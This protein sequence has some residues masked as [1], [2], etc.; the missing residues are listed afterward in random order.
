MT[1]PET[2]GQRLRKA[3]EQVGSTRR[4]K[5]DAGQLVVDIVGGPHPYVWI[6]DGSRYLDSLDWKALVRAARKAGVDV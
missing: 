6:G 1:Q 4:A 5:T 3:T 2:A